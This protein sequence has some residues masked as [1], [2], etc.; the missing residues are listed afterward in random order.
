MKVCHGI[1]DRFKVTQIQKP[2]YDFQRRCTKCECYVPI[3]M[4]NCECCKIGT[5][6][7][8]HNSKNRERYK[9]QVVYV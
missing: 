6:S 1:C 9:R 3:D 5:R 2:V 7:K 8:P 4:I